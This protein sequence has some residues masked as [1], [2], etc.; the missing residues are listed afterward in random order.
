MI[1]AH[2]FKIPVL[3]ESIQEP[4]KKY[5][6]CDSNWREVPIETKYSDIK[7]FR[8]FD[9]R[10]PNP[11]L[12]HHLEWEVDGSKGKKYTVRMEGKRWS[13]ECHAFG[14]SG[15]KRTCKHVETK[16]AELQA[17]TDYNNNLLKNNI[18]DEKLKQSLKNNWQ[19]KQRIY[20]SLIPTNPFE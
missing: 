4:G 18:S 20:K 16:K 12:E 17:Q 1:I 10:T 6:I 5:L 13:C 3:F 19:K 7:W 14:W 11:A 8:K 2:S 15:G 9:E